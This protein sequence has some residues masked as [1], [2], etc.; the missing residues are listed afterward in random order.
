[1]KQSKRDRFA[2]QRK[3]ARTNCVVQSNQRVSQLQN[4]AR[5]L[6]GHYSGTKKPR[7]ESFDRH[8]RRDLTPNNTT[9]FPWEEAGFRFRF[10]F[11]FVVASQRHRL[12]AN[13]LF[14]VC[15]LVCT[16]EACNEMPAHTRTQVFPKASRQPVDQPSQAEPTGQI[17]PAM[18]HKPPACAHCAS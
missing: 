2:S 10:R 6:A 18:Q 3:P 7:P 14:N 12:S 8:S 11:G 16:V 9:F 15:T 5:K 4:T 13:Q 17:K 1:M